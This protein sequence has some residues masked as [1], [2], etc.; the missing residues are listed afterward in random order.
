MNEN[1]RKK[2]IYAILPLVIIWA[3]FNLK[4]ADNKNE[5]S[6]RL[7]TIQEVAKANST[8]TSNREKLSLE[9]DVKNWGKD[10][11]HTVKKQKVAPK[12]KAFN[13]P[14]W[15][16]TGIMY[17]S[18]NPLAVINKKYVAEGEKVGSCKIIK[19]EQEKVI[20]EYNG[21]KYTLRVSKG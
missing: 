7:A 6:G 17:N 11:F 16:L 15:K 19:I 18:S 5:I 13:R 14:T 20:I 1:L 21:Q 2:I 3:F 8:E 9:Y 4:T 10:P 12:K